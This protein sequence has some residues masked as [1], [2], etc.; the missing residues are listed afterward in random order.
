MTKFWSV[1]R[2]L[3]LATLIVVILLMISKPKPPAPALLPE[4]RQH[5]SSAFEQKL[6]HLEQSRAHG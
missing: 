2:W 3:F 4:A 5:L 1:A 6:Q